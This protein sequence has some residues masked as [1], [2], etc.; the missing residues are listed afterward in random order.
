MSSLGADD[1]SAF[2]EAVHGY[3]PFP[4]QVRLAKQVMKTGKWPDVL[5]LPT[6]TGKTSVIDIAL[7]ALACFPQRFPRR[8]LMVVDRRVVVDQA[9]IHAQNILNQ[10]TNASGGILAEVADG[11]RGC[12]G[13]TG[14]GAPF[15]L[16]VLRGGMPREDTWAKRPDLPVV[17]LS[18]VDQVGSRLLFGGYGVSSGMAPVHAG[19]MGNDTLYFLDE[20]HLSIPFAETLGAIKTHWRRRLEAALPDRFAVV[21]MSATPGPHQEKDSVF[22]LG[23][24]DWLHDVLASR[25]KARKPTTLELV[26]VKGK[27]ESE[28]RSIFAQCCVTKAETLIAQ[29]AKTLAIIVNRVETACLAM[30]A[31]ESNT[32]VDSSLLTGRMRPLDRDTV[33]H[34]KVL[35]RVASGRIRG[36]EEKPLV[37]VATQCLE[38][39]ADFDFD[40]LVTECAS[41]DA[42]RQRFGR[43]DRL[44]RLPL[45][46]SARA[47]VLARS[48]QIG[49]DADD[50]VYG[51][52][53]AKTWHWLSQ[54]GSSLDMGTDYLPLPDLDSLSTLVAPR[55]AAPV[56]LPAHLDRWCQTR[57]KPWPVPDISL[58]LH[59]QK[60]SLPEVQV[61]WRADIDENQLAHFQDY[62]KLTDDLTARLSACPPGTLETI[63]LPLSSIRRWLQEQPDGLQD[64]PDVEG[65]PGG[66]VLFPEAPKP[67]RAAVRWTADGAQIVYAGD[68]E[69]GDTVVVP[70]TYGG[71][72]WHNWSPRTTDPVGDL[73][74]LVQ[75]VMRG[76][77]TLRLHPAVIS[78]WIEQ[79]PPL[80]TVPGES[81]VDSNPGQEIKNW[82]TIASPLVTFP[83][84][85]ILKQIAVGHRRMGLAD[86]TW[87]LVAKKRMLRIETFEN[88]AGSADEE[89]FI[90][91]EISL[92]SHCRHVRHA[93]IGFAKAIGLPIPVVEDIGLAAWLHDVGKADPRFQKML[94]GGSDV[95]L[96]MLDHPIAKSR[97]GNRDRRERAEAQRMS[98]YPPGQRHELLSIA[99]LS[100]CASA[101][102]AAN[103]PELVLYLIQTHHGFCRPFA[104][105]VSDPA[106]VRVSLVHGGESLSA[107]SN[108]NLARLDSGI[109]DRFWRMN[110]KYGWWG[111][112]GLEAILRLADHRASEMEGN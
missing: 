84:D 27:D 32:E 68:L 29:G 91:Q 99:M 85:D 66:E 69:P 95:R 107:D 77:A 60:E 112:A 73:G 65:A 17:A 35:R 50:P 37:V 14:R 55:L 94:V 97:L 6:G 54:L 24:D 26:T 61:L 8:V 38:A 104:P 111:L 7:F 31:L 110:R 62:S 64:F 90:E 83:W 11:L 58:W 81:E 74:D 12:W 21:H 22:R 63:Q 75:W 28:K 42:L 76:K 23:G 67:G 49:D 25:L 16:A 100:G 88:A 70:A 5:D 13:A 93:A 30:T 71:L 44:G 18:T 40:G 59:G 98:G 80:P 108:H 89:S 53:L 15:G 4:W 101:L 82:L 3:R 103:D 39:G 86:K 57:P 96:A 46:S 52:S 1:F 87:V 109:V 92:D 36:G 45:P 102:T 10:L 20:V 72:K 9:A 51:S 47:F 106:P 34:E 43:L 33:L 56:L 48:D 2:C 41:L 79:Y 19:L 105:P 78:Q